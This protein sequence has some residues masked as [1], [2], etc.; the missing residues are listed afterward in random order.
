M[1]WY[2]LAEAAARKDDRGV[3]LPIDLKPFLSWDGLA[4]DIYNQV[5]EIRK[6]LENTETPGSID[7]AAVRRDTSVPLSGLEMKLRAVINHSFI[8]VAQDNFIV[9]C[10]AASEIEEDHDDPLIGEYVA[11][12]RVGEGDHQGTATNGLVPY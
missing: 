2:P 12:A 7:P 8:E 5:Y 6:V 4:T 9:G 10:R 11:S 1:P 3:W